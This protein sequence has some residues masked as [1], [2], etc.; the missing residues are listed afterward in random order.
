MNRNTNQQ[1]NADTTKKDLNYLLNMQILSSLKSI[2]GKVV[3]LEQK[4]YKINQML[5][6]ENNISKKIT[7]SSTL[8]KDIFADNGPEESKLS[9]KCF[10]TG[11]VL[12]PIAQYP[13]DRTLN[14]VYHNS[15]MSYAPPI[16][17]I[18]P[19]IMTNPFQQ[20]SLNFIN[21][22]NN[23]PN[24][25]FE[26]EHN[27]LNKKR[28]EPEIN[29]N[30]E[31]E[32]NNITKKNVEKPI[33]KRISTKFVKKPKFVSLNM[34]K[35]LEQKKNL[36]NVITKSQYIYRRRKPKM[37]NLGKNKC[38]NL[39]CPHPGCDG[40]FRTKKQAAFHHF[41]MSVECH[42]DT[43]NLLKLVQQTKKI[44]FEEMKNFRNEK[45]KE[46]KIKLFNKYSILYKEAMKNISLDE[47][48][49]IITGF[50][51]EDKLIQ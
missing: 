4:N 42:N 50:N 18:Y 16:N 12:K 34:G 25:V 23:F 26:N 44:L 6:I 47:Y 46:E 40:I 3:N 29:E 27:F 17:F 49:D 13:I 43:I 2:P 9:K 51:F 15:L 10:T 33:T 35:K 1:F 28:Q 36:F 41:K 11:T 5:S 22:G 31:I 21:I 19:I 45:E 14:F 20:N 24:K 8:T 7:S 37:K 32:K 30:E 39:K 48:I 38:L